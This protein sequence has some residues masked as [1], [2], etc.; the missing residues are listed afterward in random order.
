MFVPSSVAGKHKGGAGAR[1]Q[2]VE[3]V[4]ER[5]QKHH[6]TEEYN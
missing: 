3:H 4:L 5:Y 2:I 1:E 6:G